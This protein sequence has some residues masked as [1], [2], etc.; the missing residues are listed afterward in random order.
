MLIDELRNYLNP[1]SYNINLSKDNI[2]I[3]NYHKLAQITDN[4]IS[5]DF[6]TFIL[7]INGSNFK[8]NKM[9]DKEILFNGH[10]ESMEY[11]YK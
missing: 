1:K 3:N 5:I 7:N 10:I 9:I 6:D 4:Y 11:L 8:I 2:Y